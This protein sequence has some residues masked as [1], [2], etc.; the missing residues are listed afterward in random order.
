MAFT[1]I[2]LFSGIGGFHTALKKIGGECVFASEIDNDAIEVY[3]NNFNIEV[4]GD[5]TTIDYNK[6]PNADL[7]AAGFPCQAFSKAGSQNGF[8]D[9]TKGTLFFNIK[10]ILSY[11]VEIGK[12]IKYIL[13]ENVKNLT[14]HNKQDTWKTIIRVLRDLGYIVHDYPMIMSPTDLEVPIPQSR[15][16]VY[17]Y[18]VH[19]SY[20]TSLPN[21][22]FTKKNKNNTKLFDSNILD[23]EV[24]SKYMLDNDKVKIIEMWQELLEN[25]D[26]KPSFP[27][28]G[29]YFK[30]PQNNPE[31]APDWKLKIISRNKEF[32]LEYK[33]FIDKWAKK[34]DFW[35]LK[36]TFQKFEWQCQE[37]CK[38]LKET[39]MQFRPS[40]LRAKKPTFVPALVAIAQIPVIFHK[41]KYRKLT[42]RECARLQS[43]PDSFIISQNDSKAYK[44]FGNTVNVDVVEYIAKRLL[45]V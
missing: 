7:L 6:I 44:Q 18:G 43:F 38:S 12:P 3:R 21:I 35:N 41:N 10:E 4:C 23:N 5:I 28:W 25:I 17:I 36:P 19:K 9:K 30:Y 37:D 33:D 11:F 16:R 15:D 32:Y 13:L 8:N 40:G 24:S 14:S 2:D 45:G 1:F 27:I 29:N 39:I 42:P 34:Y 22:E 26:Y 31:Q 20:N